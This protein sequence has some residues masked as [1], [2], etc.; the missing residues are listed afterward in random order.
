MVLGVEDDGAYSF[1]QVE[2]GEAVTISV[3][4]GLKNDWDGSDGYVGD[5]L[6]RR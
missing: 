6:Q 2:H 4:R 3:E 5:D 1:S